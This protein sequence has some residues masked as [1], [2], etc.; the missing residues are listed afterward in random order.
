IITSKVAILDE[1]FSC[2]IAKAHS[3]AMASKNAKIRTMKEKQAQNLQVL[4]DDKRDALLE[5]RAADI[6]VRRFA[7]GTIEVM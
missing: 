7:T 5:R 4:W 3:A 2:K 6:I 1:S